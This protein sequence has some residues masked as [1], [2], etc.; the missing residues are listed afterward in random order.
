MRCASATCAQSQLLQR[1][2]PLPGRT[3]ELGLGLALVLVLGL[4]L[5]LVR[6]DRRL[7][8]LLLVAVDQL[9]GLVLRRER[10]ALGRLAERGRR[11]VRRLR[12]HRGYAGV[13]RARTNAGAFL[14][15]SLP[16]TDVIG[17][18]SPAGGGR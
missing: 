12:R 17:R 3:S 9:R 5:A 7:R 18:G 11:R 2:E 10:P 13:C 15:A 16:R 8:V 14:S 4:L 6:A 1:N